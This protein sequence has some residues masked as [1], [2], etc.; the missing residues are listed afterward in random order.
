MYEVISTYY[1]IIVLNEIYEDIFTSQVDTYPI[2][3]F[4]YSEL[5]HLEI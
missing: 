5:P 1:I 3:M 4:G 2:K